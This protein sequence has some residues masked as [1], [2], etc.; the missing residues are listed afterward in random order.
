MIAIILLPF[1]VAASLVTLTF[2]VGIVVG[3]IR[4]LKKGGKKNGK[5]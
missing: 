4:A 5:E 3:G 2:G 1:A